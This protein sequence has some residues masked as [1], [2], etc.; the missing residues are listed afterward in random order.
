MEL[1]GKILFSGRAKGSPYSLFYQRESISG[2]AR[3]FFFSFVDPLLGWGRHPSFQEYFSEGVPEAEQAKG[4]AVGQSLQ[5]TKRV[6]GLGGSTTDPQ[7]QPWN[8]VY[9]LSEECTKR[10]ELCQTLN[11]G[12]LGYSTTQEF[13]KLVRDVIPL[14]PDLVISLSGVNDLGLPIP[15]GQTFVNGHQEVIQNT[16]RQNEWESHSPLYNPPSLT[17]PL[18]H[19]RFLLELLGFHLNPPAMPPAEP[20]G[21][22][23]NYSRAYRWELNVRMMHAVSKEMGFSFFVFLQPFFALE[24]KLLDTFMAE[25]GMKYGY[26]SGDVQKFYESARAS[27]RKMTYCHDLSQEFLGKPEMWIDPMHLDAPGHEWEAKR[28]REILRAKGVW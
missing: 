6:V 19:A 13:L 8:W 17:G 10:K 22:I 9:Y 4:F 7:T 25:R 23:D 24:P 12:I 26:D 5:G 16:L 15:T 2:Q 1:G 27:C 14:K 20:I 21:T 18:P 28:M 3:S 11:G